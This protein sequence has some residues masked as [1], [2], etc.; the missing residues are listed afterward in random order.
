[1]TNLEVALEMTLISRR[2]NNRATLRITSNM[3]QC[4]V[5]IRSI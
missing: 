2:V 5:S 1:M 4:Y 3:N